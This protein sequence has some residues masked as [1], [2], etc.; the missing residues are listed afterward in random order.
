MVTIGVYGETTV[1]IRV[2]MCMMSCAGS[3]ASVSMHIVDVSG[4]RGAGVRN[5]TLLV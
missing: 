4:A 5:C 1:N 3:C 2:H